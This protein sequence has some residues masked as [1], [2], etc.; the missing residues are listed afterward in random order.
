MEPHARTS[1]LPFLLGEGDRAAF[2]IISHLRF[3]AALQVGEKVDVASLTVQGP[4]LA[5][6]LYRNLVA[7]DESRHATLDFVQR[8]FDTALG[9]AAAYLSRDGPDRDAAAEIGQAVLNAIEAAKAGTGRLRAT[10]EG[11]RMY[12]A[13][14]DTLL[15]ALETR[16]KALSPCARGAP[17][18]A[19]GAGAGGAA[20]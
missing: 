13:R 20:K 15:V 9:L 4:G 17:T 10:Y 14:I 12:A 7:R 6:W 2:D 8:T 1:A 16:L 5:S 18:G 3:I 11:D 19:N